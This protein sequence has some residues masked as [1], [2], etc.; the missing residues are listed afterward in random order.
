MD[1]VRV[2]ITYGKALFDASEDL[3]KTD[4]IQNDLNELVEAIK[5]NPDFFSVLKSPAISND[6]KKDVI[7]KIF[8]GQLDETLI[9]FVCLLIDKSRVGSF[10]G[11][12]KEFGKCV[13][14]EKGIIGGVIYSPVAI[15]EAK[16]KK[17][18]QQTGTLL[19]KNVG[20][21]NE[22]DPS[23]IGGVKIYVDGK[24]IDASIRRKLDDLKEQ[25]L[26]AKA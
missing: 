11:I 5:A 25:L 21:K 20:L 3:N 8:K 18:E 9:D 2:D 26:R 24:L 12:A 19:K 10:L 6:E 1:S 23:L 22:I 4:I 16:L 7:L 14:E 13:E 17:F 15:P